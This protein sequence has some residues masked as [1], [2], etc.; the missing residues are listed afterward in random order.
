MSPV[1]A[2]QSGYHE[3]K[4]VKP[5]EAKKWKDEVEKLKAATPATKK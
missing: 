4:G 2:T 3:H 1:S 5:D